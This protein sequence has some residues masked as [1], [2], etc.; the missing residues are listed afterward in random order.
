MNVHVCSHLKHLAGE[1]KAMDHLGLQKLSDV[2]HLL[3]MMHSNENLKS[4]QQRL[5][6]ATL[7]HTK[8][9]EVIQ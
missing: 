2:E 5:P 7:L 9:T 1:Q 8:H 3:R 4:G 6:H